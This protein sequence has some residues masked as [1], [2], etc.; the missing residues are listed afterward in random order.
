M[1]NISSY[2]NFVRMNA[3]TFEEL[4][5]P[6]HTHRLRR[7]LRRLRSTMKMMTA[8]ATATCVLK[9]KHVVLAS[10]VIIATVLE[11][12]DEGDAIDVCGPDSGS[13]TARGKEHLITSCI[14][15]M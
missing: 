7:F 11:G 14:A 9:E 12:G 8:D 10:A 3:A 1:C 13:L 4:H 15:R 2:R 6:V 5:C